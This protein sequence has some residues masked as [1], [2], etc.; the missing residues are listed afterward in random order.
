MGCT[1]YTLAGEHKRRSIDRLLCFEFPSYDFIC[2][3]QKLRVT[4][5]GGVETFKIMG[6]FSC[7]RVCY[8]NNTRLLKTVVKTCPLCYS[9]YSTQGVSTHP[10]RQVAVVTKFCPVDFNACGSSVWNLL[11]YKFLASRIFSWI[12]DL[13]NIC[14]SVNNF[15]IYTYLLPTHRYHKNILILR[16]IKYVTQM[17]TSCAKIFPIMRHGPLFKHSADI[18]IHSQKLLAHFKWKVFIIY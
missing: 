1:R 13:W 15:T 11:H 6:E 2:F 18:F 4:N 14:G 16:S 10:E 5:T 3:C 17:Q 8:L 7:D 12:L 9:V